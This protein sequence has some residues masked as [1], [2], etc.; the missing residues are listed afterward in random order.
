LPLVAQHRREQGFPHRIFLDECHYFLS[1]SLGRQILDFQLDGYTLVT[2]RPSQLAREVLTS[3]DVFAVTRLTDHAEVDVLR[4]LLDDKSEEYID[5]HDWYDQLANLGITEAALL[6]PTREAGGRL[7][8]FVVA[9]RLTKHVRHRTKYFDVP[10]STGRRFVFTDCGHPTGESAA[11]LRELGEAARRVKAAVLI[12]HSQRHDFSHW[13][14]DLFCDRDLANDIRKLES[15]M[16]HNGDVD[17][18]V[19]GF[20][21]VVKKRYQST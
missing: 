13:V 17:S 15:T 6:P 4:D 9:P 11:T 21:E 8:R 12:N 18:F 19:K 16:N 3:I 10:V 5:S 14:A 7:R 2:Y 20:C 1:G